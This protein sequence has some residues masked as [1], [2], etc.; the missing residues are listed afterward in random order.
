VAIIGDISDR[1]KGPARF[2]PGSQELL[3]TGEGSLRGAPDGSRLTK[4]NKG[5]EEEV[6]ECPRA[7]ETARRV[8]TKTPAKSEEV[9]RSERP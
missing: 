9:T 4:T 6:I 8:F 7:K 5:K 2:Q 1:R 3:K